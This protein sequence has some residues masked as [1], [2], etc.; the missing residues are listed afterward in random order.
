MVEFGKAQ[1]F[2]QLRHENV[3]SRYHVSLHGL[4]V[5]SS[6]CSPHD[7]FR[8]LSRATLSKVEPCWQSCPVPTW[9][10]SRPVL[11]W[12][13]WPSAA[14]EQARSA[15]YDSTTTSSASM[16]SHR[17]VLSSLCE[18]YEG[19]CSLMPVAAARRYTPGRPGLKRCV[20][21]TSRSE[22]MWAK[23]CIFPVRRYPFAPAARRSKRRR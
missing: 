17:C 4:A 11:A 13:R 23:V 20:P 9:H 3:M 14:D 16:G 5:W 6:G 18:K 7:H 8:S 2:H 1:F 15:Q 22:A 12:N 21:V 10:S 19:I